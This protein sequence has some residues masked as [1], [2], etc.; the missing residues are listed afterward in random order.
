VLLLRLQKILDDESL[1]PAYQFGFEK[2]FSAQQK[3]LR[4][5]ENTTNFL[6]YEKSTATA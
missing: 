2:R 6:N 4:L 3:I 5:V 1:I